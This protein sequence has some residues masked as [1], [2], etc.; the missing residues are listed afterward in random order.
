MYLIITRLPVS[1]C[2]FY[3]PPSKNV[4]IYIYGIS[5]I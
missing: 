4:K 5:I 2:V 1:L 3:S